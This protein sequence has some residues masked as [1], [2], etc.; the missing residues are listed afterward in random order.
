MHLARGS[1]PTKTLSLKTSYV[2]VHPNFSSSGCSCAEYSACAVLHTSAFPFEAAAKVDTV[3]VEEI[4]VIRK[5]VPT[6]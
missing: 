5:K 2:C 1:R 6:P 4:G 3:E